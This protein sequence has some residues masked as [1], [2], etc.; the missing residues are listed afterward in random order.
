MVGRDNQDECRI[1]GASGHLMPPDVLM[2]WAPWPLVTKILLQ[3]FRLGVLTQLVV[4]HLLRL[5]LLLQTLTLLS[6]VL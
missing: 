5:L 2:P 3:P 1:C 6:R 4:T